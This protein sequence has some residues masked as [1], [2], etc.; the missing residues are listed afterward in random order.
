M[1]AFILLSVLLLLG[2]TCTTYGQPS[3]GS[4]YE[5]LKNPSNASRFNSFARI[6][7]FYNLRSFRA[8]WTNKQDI[9]QFLFYI[10]QSDY[11]GLN[12]NDYQPKLIYSL[13]S[14]GWH[15]Q[16]FSDSIWL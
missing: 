11:L 5:F 9:D 12:R 14:G 16:D 7:E 6:N 4:I 15:P 10:G 2:I 3:H 8:V 13:E 1:K